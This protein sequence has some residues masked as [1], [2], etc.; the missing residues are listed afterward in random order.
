MV[1]YCII[2][3][4]VLV[5]PIM[6]AEIIVTAFLPLNS[7]GSL[8]K[9]THSAHFIQFGRS[10]CCAP[11]CSFIPCIISNHSTLVLLLED[12]CSGK[13]RPTSSSTVSYFS[14]IKATLD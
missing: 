14:N 2:P 7:H 1:S 5:P 13:S 9:I 8:S 3:L 6:G 11:F 4:G 10:S 12:E